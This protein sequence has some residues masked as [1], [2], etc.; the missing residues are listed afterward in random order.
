MTSPIKSEYLRVTSILYPFSGLKGIDP[1]ILANAQERGTKVHEII[2]AFEAGIGLIDIEK[3]LEGY[4]KSYSKW[5]EGKVFK[6]K[7]ER[8]YC[9]ELMITG[10][11]D[12]IYLDGSDLVIVD[13][14]TPAKESKTWA[15]QATAYSYLAKKS[16]FKIKRVEFIKLDKTGE[17]PIVYTYEEDLDMFLTILKSYRYFYKNQDKENI[18][19]YL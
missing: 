11:I 15:M 3:Y 1:A 16:G 12:A 17:K 7:P 4:F 14:K 2:D 10:E 9:D 6:S 5:A 19:D 13:Y 18:L 8:F